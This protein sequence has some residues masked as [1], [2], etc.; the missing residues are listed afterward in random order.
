MEK[1]HFAFL[2][3]ETA[4]TGG[5]T[6]GVASCY[7]SWGDLAVMLDGIK[8]YGLDVVCFVVEIDKHTIGG[9]SSGRLTRFSML[10]CEKSADKSQRSPR[11]S[12]ADLR[13]ARTCMEATSVS[14]VSD[15]V[16]LTWKLL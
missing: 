12:R 4:V 3:D 2:I 16:W 5:N 11:R 15:S 10:S 8:G 14:W 6:F 13:P 9:S 1:Y 7:F